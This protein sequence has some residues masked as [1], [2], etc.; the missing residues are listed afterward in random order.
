MWEC[1]WYNNLHTYLDVHVGA[2]GRRI[3][4]QDEFDIV[5]GYRWGQQKFYSTLIKLASVCVCIRSLTQCWVCWVCC[6]WFVIWR[7]SIMKEIM[8]KHSFMAPRS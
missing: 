3:G 5:E 1:D 8:T 7:R 4:S 2:S 6:V